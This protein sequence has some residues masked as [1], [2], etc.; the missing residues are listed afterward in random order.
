MKL[1]LCGGGSGEQISFPDGICDLGQ[2]WTSEKGRK[3]FCL[4]NRGRGDGSHRH[5]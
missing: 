5:S 2:F 4:S 3:S 1:I